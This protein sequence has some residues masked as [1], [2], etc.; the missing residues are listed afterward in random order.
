MARQ[1]QPF[2]SRGEI[3]PKL[4]GR[5]DTAAYQAGLRKARN[6]LALVGGGMMNRP[7]LTYIGPVKYHDRFTRL[8]PF[9]FRNDDTHILE[10]GH[11]YMRILREDFYV[12]ESPFNI[13][14][15]EEGDP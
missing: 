1:I 10:F 6:T 11:G 5:V 8:I 14:N 2:F 4:Y 3:S 7:G 12:V 13:T 15:I 9:E